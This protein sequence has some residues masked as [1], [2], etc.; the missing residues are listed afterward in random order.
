[1]RVLVLLG[2]VG[3]RGLTGSAVR[4]EEDQGAVKTPLH[5]CLQV[6]SWEERR[7]GWGAAL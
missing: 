7:N 5:Q 3:N 4:Q 6:L 2:T 1:M